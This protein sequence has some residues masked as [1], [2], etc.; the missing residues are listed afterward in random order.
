MGY[1]TTFDGCFVLN[2]PLEQKQKDYLTAF[3]DT[4]RM[5]RNAEAAI[6]FPD[7]I[8]NAVDLPI[9]VEG[10]YFVGGRG[11]CGQDRDDS[12]LDYNESASTQ[13]GL[14][15]KWVPTEDGTAIEWSGAEKFYN[16]V[17]WLVYLV[18]NFL[19]PWGY[20]LNGQVDWQG[21]ETEDFGTLYVKNNR[22]TTAVGYRKLAL[23]TSV[24]QPPAKP[25]KYFNFKD[26][27][28]DA[29]SAVPR[30]VDWPDLFARDAIEYYEGVHCEGCNQVVVVGSAQQGDCDHNALLNET[31]SSQEIDFDVDEE[32]CS[33]YIG[34]S[35][36]PMMNYFYPCPIKNAEDAASKIA[37]LPL[38]VVYLRD[39]DE[40]GLALT[41]GGMDLSWEICEAYMRLNFLPPIHFCNLP[42]MATDYT[43]RR[44]WVVAG[45]KKSI[46][47]G[48]HRHKWMLE[49][50]KSLQKWYENLQKTKV[51]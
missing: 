38:C 2:K 45:C 24:E 32:V 34:T 13:P 15:C 33:G 6:Q 16:Y 18:N 46:W 19:K 25:K 50:L 22:V 41:G 31:K 44:R 5:K 7:P 17:E 12:I 21:E 1:A 3:A 39:T 8:R 42:R 26:F 29:I 47:V 10:E 43:K 30:D 36:G 37:D 9:G 4:R 48:I 27:S 35:D 51:R 14:W 23:K 28:G 49:D 11:F 40:Y 20:V